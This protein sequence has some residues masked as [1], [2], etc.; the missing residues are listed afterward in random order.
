MVGLVPMTDLIGQLRNKG[1]IAFKRDYPHGFLE[2]VYLPRRTEGYHDGDTAVSRLGGFAHSRGVSP[3]KKYLPLKKH[4]DSQETK[5]TVG[6]ADN[7]DIVINAS[8]VSKRHAV[9]IP[10]KDGTVHLADLG[11]S[12]GTT[13]NGTKLTRG[14]TVELSS[15]DSVTIWWYVFEF[16][17]P[18]HLINAFK[19]IL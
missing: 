4:S 9:F 19:E 7:N 13:V 8:G 10:R 15:G 14:Q 12:N 3:E 17:Y 5:I 11:S 16:V 18:R 6:R 2:V 1:E